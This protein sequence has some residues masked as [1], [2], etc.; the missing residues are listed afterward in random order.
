MSARPAFR[1][2]RI[3]QFSLQTKVTPSYVMCCRHASSCV[4]RPSVR[5]RAFSHTNLLLGMARDPLGPGCTFGVGLSVGKVGLSSGRRAWSVEGSM[6]FSGSPPARL[7]SASLYCQG[8]GGLFDVLCWCF[9][10]TP[11]NKT[12]PRTSRPNTLRFKQSSKPWRG[13]TSLRRHG[14]S[15][16]CGQSLAR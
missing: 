9:V 2:L 15:S 3:F 8:R 13:P 1:N 5:S 14:S 12:V 16:V 4:G 7:Y 11:H 6:A 10:M